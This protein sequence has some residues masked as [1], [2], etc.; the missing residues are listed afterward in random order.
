MITRDSGIEAEEL[1]EAVINGISNI[2]SM[3]IDMLEKQKNEIRE[4]YEKAIAETNKEIAKLQAEL[5]VLRKKEA[6]QNG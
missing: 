4:K 1:S 2:T 3:Q 5:E 6:K